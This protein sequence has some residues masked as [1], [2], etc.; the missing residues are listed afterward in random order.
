MKAVD[1]EKKGRKKGRESG[2]QTQELCSCP[3]V[4]AEGRARSFGGKLVL[5]EATSVLKRWLT[6][7]LGE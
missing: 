6:M 3:S 5:G 1:K 2:G 7:D 4:T